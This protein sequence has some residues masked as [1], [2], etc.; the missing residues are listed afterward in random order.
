MHGI[1]VTESTNDGEGGIGGPI[2]TC[3]PA[4]VM[5]YATGW[6]WVKDPWKSY[7]YHLLGG[8]STAKGWCKATGWTT[9]LLWQCRCRQV[10]GG[11]RDVKGSR[12]ACRLVDIFDFDYIFGRQGRA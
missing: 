4:P 3:V 6:K 12:F 11:F 10:T 9:D 5:R 8:A 7:G 1:A 2:M